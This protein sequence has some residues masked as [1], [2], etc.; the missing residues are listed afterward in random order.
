MNRSETNFQNIYRSYAQ[1]VYK[2]AFWLCGDSDDAK[3]IASE[4]FI[5]M[6]TA[7]NDIV[8]ETVKAYLLKI[9]RNIFLQKKRNKKQNVKLDKSIVDS[10]IRA[11]TLAEDRSELQHVLN[12]M[13]ELSEIDR[14]ALV[15]K[16]IDG[17]SY[18]EIAHVLDLSV[19]AVKVKVHRA[20][21]KLAL[22][23]STREER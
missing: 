6:W 4:T 11:D 19:S 18:Q 20:R 7:K 1:D 15:M 23:T 14:M 5:R 17:L 3:D 13:Q 22:L 2:F 21:L 10:S 16:A 9:A 12:A 8:V